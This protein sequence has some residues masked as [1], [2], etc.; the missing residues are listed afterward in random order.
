MA[1]GTSVT[2]PPTHKL[3]L[4]FLNIN[5]V[6][7][8]NILAR[9]ISSPEILQWQKFSEANVQLFG[10]IFTKEYWR[11]GFSHLHIGGTPT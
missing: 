2:P 7:D 6:S 10:G 5:Q 11:I 3:C 8:T 1:A 4:Q 9:S